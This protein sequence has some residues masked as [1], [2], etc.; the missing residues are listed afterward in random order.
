M[1]AYD[2]NNQEFSWAINTTMT[3]NIAKGDAIITDTISKI[4]T[5]SMIQ[6]SFIQSPSIKS[7]NEVK[8]EALAEGK[9]YI[10]SPILMVK[11]CH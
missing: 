3:K 5:L 7:Q 9:D 11:D 8:G 6:S 10:W 1:V 2:P 4:W